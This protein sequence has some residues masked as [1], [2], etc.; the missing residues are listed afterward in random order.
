MNENKDDDLLG[1]L[2]MLVIAPLMLAAHLLLPAIVIF[3]I[4]KYV[5]GWL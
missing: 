4:L 3:L 2:L 5:L 1:C